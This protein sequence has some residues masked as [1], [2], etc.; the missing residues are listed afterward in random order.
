MTAATRPSGTHDLPRVLLPELQRYKN[1]VMCA[2]L[3]SAEIP[4]Q[5]EVNEQLMQTLILCLLKMH[6][7]TFYLKIAGGLAP[8]SQLP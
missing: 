4:G 3:G 8:P 7:F 2:T 6:I 1:T 5:W